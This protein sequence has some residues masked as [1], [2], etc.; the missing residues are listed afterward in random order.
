M[1]K[2]VRLTVGQL[3]KFLRKYPDDVSVIVDGYEGGNSDCTVREAF[4]TLEVN[5]PGYY[6]PHEEN[7]KGN[8]V[9]VVLLE[10]LPNH[11]AI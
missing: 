10:R 8:G 9:Q 2:R 7:D 5:A 1:A 11:L 4:M 6:G 3:K